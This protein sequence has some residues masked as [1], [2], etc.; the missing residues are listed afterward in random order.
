MTDTVVFI[1][2]NTD[3]DGYMTNPEFKTWAMSCQTAHFLTPGTILKGP[4]VR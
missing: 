2:E 3:I 1:L 4:H